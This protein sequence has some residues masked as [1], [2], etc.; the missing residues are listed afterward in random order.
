MYLTY[1]EKDRFPIKEEIQELLNKYSNVANAQTLL[2][3][4][5][6][7]SYLLYITNEVK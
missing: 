3:D 4:I 1:E 2:K 6:S 5:V 7:V